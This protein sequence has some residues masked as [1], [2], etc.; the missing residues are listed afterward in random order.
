METV[1]RT[2][3][4]KRAIKR[5]T[6]K[7]NAE[8]PPEN[9]PD[10]DLEIDIEDVSKRDLIQYTGNW[11]TTI[12]LNLAFGTTISQVAEIYDSLVSKDRTLRE[13]MGK[14]HIDNEFKKKL[15]RKFFEWYKEQLVLENERLANQGNLEQR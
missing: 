8:K 5:N 3:K 9:Q 1:E 4:N 12:R 15:V 6:N 2:S 13:V 11:I 10:F 7:E 14:L